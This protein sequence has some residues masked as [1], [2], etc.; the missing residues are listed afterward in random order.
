MTLSKVLAGPFKDS[1][2]GA[3][4]SL[5]E[6][7]KPYSDAGLPPFEVHPPKKKYAVLDIWLTLVLYLVLLSSAS[8]FEWPSSMPVIS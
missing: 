5:K 7:R 8:C 2:S 6:C 4:F 1:H 3:Y